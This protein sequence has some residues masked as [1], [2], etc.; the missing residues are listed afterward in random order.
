MECD[1]FLPAFRA[2]IT[3]CRFILFG[4]GRE[5]EPAA[6]FEL[7]SNCSVFKICTQITLEI[8]LHQNKIEN[9][10]EV[11]SIC[12]T[13]WPQHSPTKCI[14]RSVRSTT[15]KSLL[16]P[17]VYSSAFQR[18]LLALFLTEFLD[19]FNHIAICVKIGSVQ[20]GW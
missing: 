17:F 14:H 2:Q 16:S 18:W 9:I 12:C 5:R 13:V 3:I 15:D 10:Y 1:C 6:S 11:I 19:T 4:M 7:F 20:P 8:G